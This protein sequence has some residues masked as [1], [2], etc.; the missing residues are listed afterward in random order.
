MDYLSRA[1]TASPGV[2]YTDVSGSLTF[3]SGENS[4]SFLIP[5]V[6]DNLA[7]PNE[8]IGLVLTNIAGAALG[9]QPV[10]MI[11]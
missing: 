8:F 9:N 10:A 6:D 7:E 3:A 4:K 11:S 1:N 5:L 2:D